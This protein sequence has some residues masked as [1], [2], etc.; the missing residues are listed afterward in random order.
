MHSVFYQAGMDMK[1]L[2]QYILESTEKRRNIIHLRLSDS[3][4]AAVE[5]VCMRTGLR[6]SQLAYELL[7][8]GLECYHYEQRSMNPVWHDEAE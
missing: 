1:N 2:T 7:Q 3:E 8:Y 5:K 6:P 4:L